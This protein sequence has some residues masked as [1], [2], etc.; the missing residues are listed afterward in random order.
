MPANPPRHGP[1]I[2]FIAGWAFV[3]AGCAACAGAVTLEDCVSSALG[4][5]AAVASLRDQVQA[6]VYAYDKDRHGRWPALSL[7]DQASYATYKPGAFE[8]GSSLNDGVDDMANA[9]LS[10]DLQQWIASPADLSRLDI[11]RNRLLLDRARAQLRHDVTQAFNKIMVL[12]LKADERRRAASYMDSHIKD[13]RRLRALGLDVELDLLRAGS[14]RTSLDLVAA[15]QDA[16]LQNSLA[17]LRSLTGMDLRPGDFQ[18][19]PAWLASMTAE[20]GDPATLVGRHLEDTLQ[21]QLTALDLASAR[22]ATRGTGPIAAPVLRAGLNHAF[23]A[24]DP[25]TPV[26]QVYA[27][28]T[29]NAFDWGRRAS[30]GRQ[31]ASEFTAQQKETDD[32]LRQLRLTAGQLAV[33]LAA[34]RKA[35]AISAELLRDAQKGLDIAEA[36][37]RQ[38][39]IKETDVLS[40][41]SDFLNAE[42]QQD[43]ALQEVLD[44]RAEWE[45]LWSGARP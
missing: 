27:S 43:G 36:Y 15:A 31:R 1:R 38:G 26:D 8:P 34:A 42:D 14:Q 24:I 39:K 5:S 2:F 37:Y 40:V 20:P 16:D 32:Q 44:Q 6:S 11:Q 18:P 33:D 19:D 21:G 35:Y 10:T 7:S 25:A 45:A 13:I 22:M 12:R 30:E 4:A 9:E 41:F 17:A 23:Q 3:L 28:L 29:L